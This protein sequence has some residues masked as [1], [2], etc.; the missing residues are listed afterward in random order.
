MAPEAAPTTPFPRPLP[1]R[2]WPA[3]LAALLW[4]MAAPGQSAPASWGNY[5]APLLTGALVAWVA[6][7]L[8]EVSLAGLRISRPSRA[9]QVAYA[10][11]LGLGTLGVAVMAL[12]LVGLLSVGSL[13]LVLVAGCLGFPPTA[14]LA[15]ARAGLRDAFRRQHGSP[16]VAIAFSILALMLVSYLAIGLCPPS[17]TDSLR[18]HLRLP[19]LYL[20]AGRFVYPERNHFAQF[21]LAAE[22][23]Y[24]VGLALGGPNGATLIVVVAGLTCL[25]GIYGHA[26]E[27]FGPAAGIASAAIFGTT[28]LVGCLFGATV[29]D[30]FVC[31]YVVLGVG[32]VWS[33]RQQGSPAP[34]GLL[35]LAGLCGGLAM[36]TKLGGG[37]AAGLTALWAAFP[38]GA[39]RRPS[40]PRLVAVG[41]PAVLVVAPWLVKTWAV[42]GN[43]IFPFLPQLLDGRGWR[44]EWTANYAAEVRSYGFMNGDAVD[45]LVSPIRIATRWKNYGTPVPLGPLY[46]ALLV[47]LAFLGRHGRPVWELTGW[48][49]AFY[50]CWLLTAQVARFVLPGLAVFSIVAGFVAVELGRALARGRPSLPVPLALA[51]VAMAAWT[52]YSQWTF[53][54]PYLYLTGQMTRDEYLSLERPYYPVVRYANDKLPPGSRVLFV[55]E[56]LSY[57][58]RVPALVETG[59]AGVT[60]VDLAN[61]TRSPTEL[62]RA[63]LARGFTHVL[64]NQAAP[65]QA[66]AVKLRYF[67]WRDEAARD[68]F[69]Q[70]LTDDAEALFFYEG[71]CLYR[72]TPRKPG[73]RP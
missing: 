53:Y 1:V 25:L 29:T 40:L 6:A 48:C 19:E 49:A 37:Y 45:Y 7:G 35:A 72:L 43:P 63:M 50:A 54:R 11:A 71:V 42:T 32:A 73:E 62:A 61:Q 60:A 47:G 27:H 69:E 16:G 26:G 23:L 24:T 20:Q 58:L 64:Y 17:D 65:N 2:L 41:A 5:L 68:R 38:L 46:L 14:A 22:M 59:F 33:Y 30:L 36:A 34:S 70:M 67:S 4:V 9:Q 57:G 66:W 55:G 15:H 13:T 52:W 21:P 8:G 56:T 10:I 31:M 44:P 12:A 18:Y 28:P 51:I 3:A 39:S